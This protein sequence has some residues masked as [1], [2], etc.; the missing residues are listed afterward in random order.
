MTRQMMMMMVMVKD[1]VMVRKPTRLGR[2][3]P[4][5]DDGSEQSLVLTLSCAK[6]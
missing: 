1:Q 3:H 5:Q 6:V 2:S 4:S